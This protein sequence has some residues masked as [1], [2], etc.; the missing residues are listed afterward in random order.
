MMRSSFRIATL[1]LLCVG[2][3]TPLYAQVGNSI[4]TGLAE[5]PSQAR[6]PGVT[7]T[8]TNTQTGVQTVVITNESGVYNIPNLIPGT[9]ALRASLPGFQTQTFEQ[10]D[11][12][13]NQTRRFNFSLRIAGTVTQVEVTVDAQ[14]LLTQA[15]GTVGDVLPQN[16][17]ATLP[18]VGNDVLD[19][20]NVLGGVSLAPTGAMSFSEAGNGA[21]S[22]FTT[23][24]GIS[25]TY[26]NTSVNGLTVTDNFYAGVGEPDNTSGILSVT[27]INPDL[28]SEVRL[29]LTPVDAELGRGNGQIQLTTRSGTNAFNGAL[30]WDVRNP[31]LNAR[32]WVDNSTL[33]GPPTQDWYNQN[34]FTLSYGGPIIR[35]KTFFFALWDQQIVRSRTNVNNTVLT[36]CARNGIFRYYPGWVND[37]ALGNVP[38][39]TTVANQSRP[40]VDINGNPLRPTTNP[41]GS[42]YTDNLRYV[43]VFGPIDFSNFPSAVASDC[44]NI[45]LTNGSLQG[46]SS[47]T[48]AWDTNRWNFDPTGFVSKV[49]AEMPTPNNFETGDGLNTAGFRYLRGQKG[50]D[51]GGFLGAVGTTS[52][53]TNRKQL[54]LKIDHHFTSSHKL[55][56]QWSYERNDAFIGAPNYPQGFWGSVRRRPHTFSGNLNSTISPSMVNEFRFGLRRT[57]NQSLEAMDNPGFR[58]AAR[59]FF[60]VINGIPVV[61]SLPIVGSPMMNA[62]NATQGNTTRTFTFADTLSW[63]RGTHSFRFGGEFR[64]NHSDVFNNI[65]L[66]PR[67]AAGAGQ[68]PVQANGTD[69]ESLLDANANYGQG[70]TSHFQDGNQG[71]LENLLLLQSGSIGNITQ[72]YFVE[73]ADRLNHFES[74]STEAT[75]SRIWKQQEIAVFA[76]DD[77]KLTRDLTTNIGLRWEYYGVPWEDRGLLPAPVG[78]R[79][80]AGAFG[81]SGDGWEDWWQANPKTNGSPTVM[82]HI[83]KN[84][85]NPGRSLYKADRN[86]FGPVLGFSWNVPWF[87]QGKTILRGGYSITFQGGGN[88]AALDGTAGEVP[89]AVWS[90]TFGAATNTYNR[91]ANFGTAHKTLTTPGT[92]NFR[93]YPYTSVVP[94]PPDGANAAQALRPMAPVPLRF[95]PLGGVP[96]EFFDDNYVAPYVQNFTLSLT[97]N[98][99][100]KMTLDV[101]YVGTVAKKLFAEVPVNSPNFLTNGLK[102]A[103]DLARSGQE[104][105][106]LNSL[107]SSVNSRFNNSGADWLR[108]QTTG[109]N[110]ANMLAVGNY[111]G[112]ADQLAF[113]NGSTANGGVVLTGEPGEA[114]LV[115]KRSGAAD[116]FIIANPQFGPLNIV[117]N[118]NSSNYH[119]L[120]TQWTLRPT[121]GINYQSTFTWSRMLGAPT[122]VNQGNGSVSFYSMDR[123]AE[124]YGLQFQHRK[125]DFRSH[126][127]FVLPFGP[128]K[129]V[130]GNSTGWVS[131]AIEDWQ[132]SMIFNMSSGMPNTIVGRSA[133][134]ESLNSSNF[135]FP[136]ANLSPVDLSPAGLARFGNFAHGI[137]KVHWAEGAATGTYFNDIEFVRVPDPQCATVTT[138]VSGAGQ[139]LQGRCNNALTAVAVVNP[140]GS[141][142]LVFQNAQPGTRGNLGTNTIEGPGMWTLDG[143]MSKAFQIDEKRR[144][145]IRFDATN[146]LNHA[147]PCSPGFCPGTARGTNLSL[148]GTTDFGLI[149]VKSALPAR[150]FQ[151]SLRLDF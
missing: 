11:L 113:T 114:G 129:L 111:A 131:R 43:S 97:R 58:D 51:G 36:P 105:A 106:L 24:A 137:G 84:S 30:R 101:R 66:I 67:I 48:S 149:G 125:F 74:F 8:A 23:L 13:G 31:A 45:R 6:I 117:T 130:L 123:R 56:S 146:I 68:V 124:D 79:N 10:I 76:Q 142:T 141:Q 118:S 136:P 96:T 71:L 59:D 107:T 150:Q 128:N 119:S 127:T 116:N 17:V 69:F 75:R 50:T 83:G 7:V 65:N 135:G 22:R 144:V 4:L 138:K 27:R 53:N 63:T 94:L 38:A 19:L 126:G 134:Y 102:E 29:I 100:R 12:G 91:L 26:V 15:G 143:S 64:T 61:V 122:A 47:P 42:T 52:D 1:L 86:N 108:A 103:F 115:L 147:A 14:Q 140:D 148:N 78:G 16:A 40:V 60:P 88:V 109:A 41:N 87:G 89:G 95:R 73:Y 2:L 133:L 25:A 80:L 85:P 93:D 98:L 33:G 70:N 49:F 77:W 55:A 104:S 34:Q 44:S 92:F 145:Q 21:G 90:A 46:A 5:D 62:G 3:V 18:L 110:M 151:G 81:I 112:L 39:P 121:M 57:N 32:S 9:Y 99:G 28:V 120:Q 72:F 37:D 35:S 20:V 54:N 132:L 139:T 82:E